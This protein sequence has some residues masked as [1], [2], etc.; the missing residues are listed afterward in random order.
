M[1]CE[2]GSAP[3]NVRQ[4]GEVRAE[5]QQ[6]RAGAESDLVEGYSDNGEAELRV[7]LAQ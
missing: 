7:H 3:N 1:G 2:L 6:G 4:C 5:A